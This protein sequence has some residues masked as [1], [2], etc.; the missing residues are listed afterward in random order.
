VS[1]HHFFNY[2]NERGIGEMDKKVRKID[3]Q[4]LSERERVRERLER[5]EE[6]YIKKKT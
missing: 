5:F 3:K 6:K 2:E 1:C 4:N